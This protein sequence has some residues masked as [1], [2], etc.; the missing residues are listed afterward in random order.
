[1]VRVALVSDFFYP[2]VGGAEVHMY[3]VSALLTALGHEV[4][5]VTHATPT[6]RGVKMLVSGVKVYYLPQLPFYNNTSFPTAFSSLPMLRRVFLAE[7]IQLVH[8]HAA[9]SVLAHEALLHANVMGLATCFTDHSLFGF[10]D[11]S[12]ILTN[13]LLQ[14]SLAGVNRVVCVSN[15]SKVR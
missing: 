5:V 1:M 6:H 2:G 11:A 15:C 8:G 12:S 9:F 13:K 14:A 10:S 3:C 7:R 4:T